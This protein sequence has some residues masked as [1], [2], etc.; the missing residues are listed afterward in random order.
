MKSDDGPTSE[1]IQ[2]IRQTRSF[3]RDTVELVRIQKLIKI[4]VSKIEVA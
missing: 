4:T 3:M 1:F 2:G